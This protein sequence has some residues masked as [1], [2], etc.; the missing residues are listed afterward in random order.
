MHLTSDQDEDE[1]NML[2]WFKGNADAVSLMR[3]WMYVCH[4]WDDLIDGDTIRT[5]EQIN[6]AFWVCVIDMP[7]N[8]FYRRNFD[9]LQ[10]VIATHI[11]DWIASNKME[12]SEDEGEQHIAYTLRCNV[13]SLAG[14][15][16]S[17]IA[18]PIWASTVQY[19]ARLYAQREP[20]EQYLAKIKQRHED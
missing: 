15:I 9:T 10:P 11:I 8:V 18:G 6:Q 13:V 16:A 5:P 20:M 12:A 17:I 2:R 4:L 3:Q 14:M 7:R 19:E 1:R